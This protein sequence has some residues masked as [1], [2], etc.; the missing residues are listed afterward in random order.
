ML[1]RVIKVNILAQILQELK[2]TIL[3]LCAKEFERIL[4]VQEFMKKMKIII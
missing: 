4:S 3:Q 2:N 1:M